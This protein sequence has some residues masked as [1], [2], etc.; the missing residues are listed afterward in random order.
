ML[1]FY[2]FEDNEWKIFHYHSAVMPK[3]FLGSPAPAG[4]EEKLQ[5]NLAA[6][7]HIPEES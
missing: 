6:E 3:A 5:G 7:L 4:A 1:L 2:V